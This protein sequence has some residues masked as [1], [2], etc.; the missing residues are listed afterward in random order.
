MKNKHFAQI[1]AVLLL[2]G[3]AIQNAAAQQGQISF[4]NGISVA[5]NTSQNGENRNLSNI[6]TSSSTDRNVIHRVM[7]DRKSKIYFGYD[8]EVFASGDAKQFEVLISPLTMKE[9]NSVVERMSGVKDFSERS[10]PKYPSKITIQSGDTIVLDI[11]E[12]PQT[13]EKIS[14]SIKITQG[15]Q[16]NFDY[17]FD[18]GNPKDFTINDVQLSLLG[19]D[20]YVNEEKV[21]FGGGGMYGA[22]LWIYFPN[23]GRFIFSPIEQSAAEFQKIGVI[24]DKT[25]SFNYAGVS[26]K[27]VSNKPVLGSGGKWNLWVMFD[28]NYKPSENL[29]SETPF[30]FGAAGK[31]EYLLDNK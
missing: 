26:Y 8:L 9:V 3:G 22:V 16:K 1:F 18:S 24:A 7:I 28:E 21:K 25:I 5:I 27:F 19:F 6:Y 20:V 14:D 12:N 11:L 29:S 4:S 17:T 30:S 13:K 31:V 10:L 2:V 15:R 23:K